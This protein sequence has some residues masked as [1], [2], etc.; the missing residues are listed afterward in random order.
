MCLI[1]PLP[2]SKL[3]HCIKRAVQEQ[4]ICHDSV[5]LMCVETNISMSIASTELVG[6]AYFYYL[7][8]FVRDFIMFLIIYNTFRVLLAY[9]LCW[10]HLSFWRPIICPLNL[11]PQREPKTGKCSGED[12][13]RISPGWNANH[14]PVL[15]PGVYAPLTVSPRV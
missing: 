3:T 9:F 13:L 7:L 11:S 4:Q 2:P 6:N 14:L 10:R 8:Y 1:I 12:K 15:R 5:L